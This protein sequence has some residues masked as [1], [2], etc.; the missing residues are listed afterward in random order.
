MNTFNRSIL[1]VF[2]TAI[3]LTGCMETAV[4]TMAITAN[5]MLVISFFLFI[6][7]VIFKS[8]VGQ[9][10]ALVV[11]IGTYIFA[12]FYENLAIKYIFIVSNY[13]N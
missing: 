8:E 4:K 10:V 5:T 12:Y 9:V 7:S 3:A 6:T 13:I 1:I 2:I 11:I